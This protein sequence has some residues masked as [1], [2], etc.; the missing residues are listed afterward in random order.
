[1]KKTRLHG[2]FTACFQYLKGAY[3]HEGKG[4]FILGKSDKKRVTVIN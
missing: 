2:E 3:K 4:H 1:M